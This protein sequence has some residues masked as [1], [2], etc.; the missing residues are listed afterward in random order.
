MTQSNIVALQT[1][2]TS[3]EI[4]VQK[5]IIEIEIKHVV[6][7]L[8]KDFSAILAIDKNL[9]RQYRSC[10]AALEILRYHVNRV[11]GRERRRAHDAVEV[12]ENRS[13]LFC[14][15]FEA[16]FDLAG[17]ISHLVEQGTIAR[18]RWEE[19]RVE[20]KRYDKVKLESG[21]LKITKETGIVKFKMEKREDN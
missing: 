3:T 13:I 4:A 5:T 11:T 10:F 19:R 7:R 18:A 8:Y 2:N 16:C 20:L 9:R 14:I 6:E 21:R 12:N 1:V 17:Q 15:A